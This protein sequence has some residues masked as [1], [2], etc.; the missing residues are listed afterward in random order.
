MKSNP[1]RMWL[2]EYWGARAAYHSKMV[3]ETI[4][5][6]LAAV[7]EEESEVDWTV[8]RIQITAIHQLEKSP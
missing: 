8:N 1:Y 3:H 7:D 6:A 2:I 4:D 5:G